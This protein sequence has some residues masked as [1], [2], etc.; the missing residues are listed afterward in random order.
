MSEGFGWRYDF[1]GGGSWLRVKTT[2]RPTNEDWRTWQNLS[3]LSKVLNCPAIGHTLLARRCCPQGISVGAFAWPIHCRPDH[4]IDLRADVAVAAVAAHQ[5]HVHPR[6]RLHVWVPQNRVH[7]IHLKE[8]G[9]QGFRITGI[10]KMT[11]FRIKK[12]NIFLWPTAGRSGSGC[13]QS[14]QWGRA[15]AR[16]WKHLRY[17][18]YSYYGTYLKDCKLNSNK[19]VYR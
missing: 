2:I 12:Y 11:E 13:L 14:V 15:L 7:V 16:A 19:L 5:R 17:F 9:K 1:S 3:I 4:G 18:D 10:G 6:R 8:G